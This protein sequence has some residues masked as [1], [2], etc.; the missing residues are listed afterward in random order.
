[1]GAP[2]RARDDRA[3]HDDHQQGAQAV[4]AGRALEL[5]RAGSLAAEEGGPYVLLESDEAQALESAV[6]DRVI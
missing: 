2:L 3:A 1:M 4:A 5:R 6:T